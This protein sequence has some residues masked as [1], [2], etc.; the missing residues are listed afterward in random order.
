MSGCKYRT[1]KHNDPDNLADLLAKKAGKYRGKLI[2]VDGIFSMDGDMTP[3]DEIVALA[4]QYDARVMVDEAHGTGVVGPSGRGV[5]EHFG[6]KD[7]VDIVL[8][9][10]SKALGATGGFIAASREVVNYIRHYSRSYMFSASP[11]PGVIASVLAALDIFQKE[12]W[13][14]ERLWKNIFY[15]YD[16]LK[17]T[18]F[19]VYPSFPQSAILTV[20]VGEDMT[21]RRMSKRIYEKGL[22]VSAV[23]Y[24]AVPRN[25]GKIRLSVSAAHKKEQLDTALEILKDVGKEFNII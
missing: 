21:V 11:T 18:G 25:E 10:F 4:K 13:I 3:L 16:G 17:E 15:L 14:R 20:S 23:A 2:V 9:T 24:P 5:V 22:F 12:P 7:D 19:S 1:F 8:G 6:L